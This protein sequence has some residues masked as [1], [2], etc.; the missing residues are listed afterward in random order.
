MERI[1][2]GK[3]KKEKKKNSFIYN[4]TRSISYLHNIIDLHW[5]VIVL[6][7]CDGAGDEGWTRLKPFRRSI[8]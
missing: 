5:P 2:G 3:K 6:S 7:L 8:S 4:P 1:S